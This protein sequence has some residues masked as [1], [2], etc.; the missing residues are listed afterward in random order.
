MLSARNRIATQ[1]K[2]LEPF[3]I[4]FPLVC[5]EYNQ[6]CDGGYAFLQSKWSQDV[7]LIPERCM[8][9]NVQGEEK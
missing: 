8:Q 9:Y 2:D 5:G 6:G 1:N 3:S 4:T 7:G